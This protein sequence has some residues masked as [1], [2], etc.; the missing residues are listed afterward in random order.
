MNEWTVIA[1]LFGLVILAAGLGTM[2]DRLDA[3]KGELG[4]KS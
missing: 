1:I 4:R 2:C 3:R